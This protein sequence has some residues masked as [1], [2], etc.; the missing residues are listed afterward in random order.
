MKPNTRIA[1]ENKD[2]KAKVEIVCNIGE[3]EITGTVLLGLG[4]CSFLEMQ[5]QAFDRVADIATQTAAAC[6]ESVRTK[7]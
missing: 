5:A 7:G 3:E 6:R 4:D 1:V 2:G